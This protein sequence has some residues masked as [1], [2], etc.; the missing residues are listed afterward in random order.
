MRHEIVSKNPD[1]EVRFYLSVDEGSYVTPHWH[2]SI[3]MVYVIKGAITI[4]FE[5]KKVKVSEKEFCIIN[6]RTVHSVLSEKNEALVLQIPKELMKKYMPD[7][8]NY[9]FE[10]EM[11]PDSEIEKTKLERVKKIFTDMHVIYEI[12]PEGYLL[13]FN[14]ILYDL[15]FTL[16]HSYSHK[17]IQ[18][19]TDRASKYLEQLNSIMT[20][21]KSHYREKIV[22]AEVAEKYG[23]NEDYLMKLFKKQTGMTIIEYLYSYRITRVYQELIN[24]KKSVNDI[25]SENGCSNHRVAMRVFKE[26]YGCTPKEKRLKM[27]END[28][29]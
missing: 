25:F 7:I 21:L 15:L 27:K 29:K 12:R 14:A 3:E 9:F 2:D 20:Y 8:D 16:M 11:N 1:I 10:I 18:K 24:T 5:N 4:G 19:S 26:I 6:S 22:I 23:Y 13:K 28:S 17:I